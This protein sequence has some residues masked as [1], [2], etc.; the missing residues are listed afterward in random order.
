MKNLFYTLVFIFPILA[1]GTEFLGKWT[2]NIDHELVVN[3]NEEELICKKVCGKKEQCKI[4]Q[5]VCKNCIGTNF[6]MAHIFQNFN[7]YFSLTGRYLSAVETVTYLKTAKFVSIETNSPF[8]VFDDVNSNKFERQLA[9]ICGGLD[10]YPLVLAGLD[11][12]G[13]IEGLD[14]LVC[15]DDDGA[16]LFELAHLSEV[17]V[18]LPFID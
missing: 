5:P 9:K 1:S 13:R 10:P 2:K 16:R 8:N 17:L 4:K 6:T 15:H 12:T 3:C 7:E 14:Y 11:R 18:A